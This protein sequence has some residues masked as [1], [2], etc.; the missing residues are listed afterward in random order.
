MEMVERVALAM[1]GSG[2]FEHV[3]GK[4]GVIWKGDPLPEEYQFRGDAIARIDQLRARAAIE[5]MR[6]PTDEMIVA[7]AM[8]TL[9][10][11]D[12]PCQ[13]FAKDAWFAMIDAALPLLPT[14]SV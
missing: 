14:V 5:A 7:G 3:S 13:A 6:E 8:V 2:L 9:D 1:V 10:E 12:N 4:Y 11:M